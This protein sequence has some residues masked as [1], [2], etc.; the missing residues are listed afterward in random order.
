MARRWGYSEGL[1]LEESDSGSSFSGRASI[2]GLERLGK[3][4]ITWSVQNFFK[5]GEKPLKSN[6]EINYETQINTS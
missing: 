1:G 2:K 4:L 3:S 5:W 6:G